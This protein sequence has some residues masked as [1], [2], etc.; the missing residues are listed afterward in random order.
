[1]ATTVTTNFDKVERELKGFERQLPFIVAGVV[2]DLAFEGLKAWQN[3]LRTKLDRP[4]PYT[5]RSAQVDRAK[6]SDRPILARLRIKRAP[7]GH[8]RHLLEGGRRP[9]RPSEQRARIGYATPSQSEL[10]RAADRFGNLS[11]RKLITAID[12]ARDRAT[13]KR[14]VVITEDNRDEFDGREPGLYERVKRAGQTKLRPVLFIDD[15]SAK[16]DKRIEF[17]RPV[18]RASSKVAERKMR[19]RVVQ[20]IKTARR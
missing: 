18:V 2:N 3:E 13:S 12:R 15:R 11:K 10:K 8:L 14:W 5:I 9:Q 7:L 16:Y 17:V 19:E 20:A 4:K 1:M 6:R